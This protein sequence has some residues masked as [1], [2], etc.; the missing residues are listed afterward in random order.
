MISR[1]ENPIFLNEFLD[2]TSTIQNKSKGTVSEYNYDLKHFFQY[3]VARYGDIDTDDSN[4]IKAIDI[5]DLQKNIITKVT[6]EDIHA[7]LHYLKS[8]FNLKATTLSRK[9]AAIRSFFNYQCTIRRALDIN[10]TVGLETPKKEKTLP[11]Y[12]DLSE[13]KNLLEIA[14]TSNSNREIS[15]SL[16]LRNVCILTFFLNLGLRRA[17]LVGINIGDINFFDNTLTVIGKGNKERMVYL[18]K[19]CINA[20]NNYL[21]V[22]PKE[23]IKDKDALFLSSVKKRIS[24]RAIQQML[25]IELKKAGISTRG[26]TPHKL[27][28]T[29]ATL[30][31]QYGEVDIRALQKVLRTCKYIYN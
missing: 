7:F 11:K 24:R 10:P 17:E 12:L 27:R 21:E 2:Y 20:I 9:V 4:K 22:R 13:S 29:A 18:N 3:I 19:A 25:E 16:A 5:R 31:Y 26:I 1:K 14:A 6:L 23:G 8:E 28:H 15:K 30:M